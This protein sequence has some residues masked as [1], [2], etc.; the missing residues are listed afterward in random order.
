MQIEPRFRTIM[1]MSLM[2]IVWDIRI[3]QGQA[4][5][6]LSNKIKIWLGVLEGETY[7]GNRNM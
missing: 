4:I 6:Y 3:W 5:V 7:Y 2:N 1:D